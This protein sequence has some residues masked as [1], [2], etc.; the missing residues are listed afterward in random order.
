M[1]V[2]SFA[3]ALSLPLVWGGWADGLLARLSVSKSIV[4]ALLGT[5]LGLH[6]LL[7]HW[8]LTNSVLTALPAALA[9]AFPAR[10]RMGQFG[11]LTGLVLLSGLGSLELQALPLSGLDPQ[12]GA[13]VT[14]AFLSG[15]L[16]KDAISAFALAVLSA[17]LCLFLPATDPSGGIATFQLVW[18]AGVAALW[19]GLVVEF[20]LRAA[21]LE[22]RES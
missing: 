12:V 4:L 16:T 21:R 14:I 13:A 19:W 18:G 9:L 22:H 17:V 20:I 1:P 10:T 7:G 3:L 11:F 15:C 8:G 5:I 6:A 2:G